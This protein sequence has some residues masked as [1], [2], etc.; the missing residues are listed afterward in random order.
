[1]YQWCNSI[2]SIVMNWLNYIVLCGT[3]SSWTHIQVLIPFFCKWVPRVLVIEEGL[4][5][6]VIFYFPSWKTG[7][8][9]FKPLW[10]LEKVWNSSSYTTGV[11]W[12]VMSL[13]FLV[14]WWSNSLGSQC[15][16]YVEKFSPFAPALKDPGPEFGTYFSMV[17][18]LLKCVQ[19][20]FTQWADLQQPKQ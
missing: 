8:N 12:I 11:L 1:M 17:L 2:D 4:F 7:G 18:D 15:L 16:T 20:T 5:K 9:Y 6:S 3:T 14:N 10:S 13:K 19:F